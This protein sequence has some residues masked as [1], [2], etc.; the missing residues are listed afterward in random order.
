MVALCSGGQQC[1]IAHQASVSRHSIPEH[2]G[3]FPCLQPGKAE[4]E[5]G[6]SQRAPIYLCLKKNKNKNK[7]V[8]ALYSKGIENFKG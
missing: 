8:W 7:T 2:P 1:S 3:S 6:Q 4:E 5:D